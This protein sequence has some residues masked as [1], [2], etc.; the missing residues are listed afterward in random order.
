MTQSNRATRSNVDINKEAISLFMKIRRFKTRYE[1]W[2]MNRLTI[3]EV[4]AYLDVFEWLDGDRCLQEKVL[5]VFNERTTRKTNI[6]RVCKAIVVDEG[7]GVK[8]VSE[9]LKDCTLDELPADVEFPELPEWFAFSLDLE[10]RADNFRVAMPIDRVSRKSLELD[11]SFCIL[12]QDELEF[13]VLVDFRNRTYARIVRGVEEP[14]TLGGYQR[15]ER[16]LEGTDWREWL[17]N[18]AITLLRIMVSKLH[19][20][21]VEP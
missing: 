3:D 2:G 6:K 16:P 7:V 8:P 13:G 21:G 14:R 4:C 10:S 18:D 17:V 11:C 20:E 9:L 12:Y 1:M 15:Y 5:A 19:T